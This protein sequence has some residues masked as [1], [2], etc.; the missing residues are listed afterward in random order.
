M[1]F[2]LTHEPL[3]YTDEEHEKAKCC[4]A[5][6]LETC[7]AEAEDIPGETRACYP[8]YCSNPGNTCGDDVPVEAW[9]DLG[10]T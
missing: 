8:P 1:A 9:R 6:Y 2:F 4:L 5:D 3:E 10:L 7:G